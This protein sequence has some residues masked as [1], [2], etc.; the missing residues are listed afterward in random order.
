MDQDNN[1][2]F[3]LRIP[4]DIEQQGESLFRQQMWCWGQDV[5]RKEGN[6][7]LNY[8]FTCERPPQGAEKAS[9]AYLLKLGN[10]ESLMLWTFG[11]FYARAPIGGML[12]KRQ[13]FM[14]LLTPTSEALTN[15]WKLA[16]FPEI[17][18]PQTPEEASTACTLLSEALY[19]VSSY[20]QWIESKL[21]LEYRQRCLERWDQPFL[22]PESMAAEWERLAERCHSFHAHNETFSGVH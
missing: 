12:L 2:P 10:Q 13:K 15:T 6:L 11:L 14:P 22:P 16:E 1:T 3:I 9:T 18:L 8:G 21:G 19:W 7:L 5:K 17:S 4:A 20:E